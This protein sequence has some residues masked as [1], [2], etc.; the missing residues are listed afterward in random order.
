M[1][2][3]MTP[4]ETCELLR[5]SKTT[6]TKL[7]KNGLPVIKLGGAHRYDPDQLVDYLR[8]NCTKK[9]A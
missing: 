4:K 9:V 3:L 5:V 8:S 1:E 2:K 6:L 7:T